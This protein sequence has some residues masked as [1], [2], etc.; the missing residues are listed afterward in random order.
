MDEAIESPDGAKQ[1]KAIRN[2]SG[3]SGDGYG[4][5]TISNGTGCT[6]NVILIT[7]TTYYCANAGDSRSALFRNGTTIPL[8][9]D[10]KP[11]SAE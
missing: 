9:Q 3:G 2:K 7:Q 6:A 11:E 1:L 4:D 8:S 10:H 5:D